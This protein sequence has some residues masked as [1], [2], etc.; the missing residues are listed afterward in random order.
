MRTTLYVSLRRADKPP[1]DG[2]HRDVGLE[3]ALLYDT[4]DA[5]A[6][7]GSH[8]AGGEMSRMI[9]DEGVTYAIDW[10][11]VRDGYVSA[12]GWFRHAVAPVSA[13]SVLLEAPGTTA[14][15]E[16]RYGVRRGD[17]TGSCGFVV[18]GRA[19]VEPVRRVVL[20][21]SLT[22]GRTCRVELELTAATGAAGH[23]PAVVRTTGAPG[24]LARL[25][26]RYRWSRV[27]LGLLWRQGRHRW[28][29]MRGRNLPRFRAPADAVHGLSIGRVLDVLGATPHGPLSLMI[30]NTL[31]GGTT[32]YRERSIRRR[33]EAGGAV[34]LWTYDFHRLR[35]FLRYVDPTHDQSFATDSLDGL[36]M[37]GTAVACK[38]VVLNN[39][40]SFPDPLLM[41]SLSQHLTWI[42]GAALT[43]A[44]HDY[45]S[46]CPSWNLLDAQGRFCGVPDLDE[47]RRCLPRIRGEVRSLVGC[48]DIDR[49]RAAWGRCL[50][51]ATTILCFSESSRQLLVRAYPAVSRDAYVVE[52]HAVDDLPRRIARTNRHAPLHIGVVGEITQPKGAGIVREMARLI[53]A[54]SLPVR[55]TVIGQLEATPESEILRVLGPYRREQLPDLVEG[56]G[57]NVF[58][59]PSIWPETFSY[60]A[61][62]LMQ[63]GVPLAVFDLGAPAE[64]IAGYAAGLR[65]ER[66]DASLALERLMAFHAALQAPPHDG[67]ARARAD[68]PP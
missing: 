48:D 26:Q 8:A 36:L 11:F 31:G 59:L 12:W 27:L 14:R 38:D 68:S 15:V 57:A 20:E 33:T 63:L 47:C 50:Q 61:E 45:L 43:V 22:S 10:L 34:L 56:S 2:V 62:E 37:L 39:V 58:L 32:L 55:I 19:P 3:Q 54:R 65:I 21:A 17:V 51:Q 35:Y 42:T 66:V 6:P 13:V 29:R 5:D 9:L 49:W 7:S 16:G 41:V 46:V 53:R 24:P 64:R 60:V 52:P 23:P 4:H 44:V 1:L 67:P 18:F 30:D 28:R 25:R 40:C